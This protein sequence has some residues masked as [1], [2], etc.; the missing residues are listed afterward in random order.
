MSGCDMIVNLNTLP[1]APKV[2]DG[3]RIKRAY[4]GDLG[5]ILDFIRE[6]FAPM[7]VYEAQK[8]IM[9]SPGTCFI[10]TRDGKLLGFACYDSSAKGFFGPIGVD[11]AARG[12][13]V[14]T[15][16]L[17]RTLE[18]MR[19]AGYGYGIIGWVSDARPFYEKGVG[20]RII[21]GGEPENSVYKNMVSM[22]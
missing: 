21:E 2:P 20:A 7:W 10:A 14:G 18:A 17:F 4:A 15:A 13:D 3:V 1:D 19:E 12:Q 16:L 6:R 9:Q 5:V 22:Q 11:E 8:A